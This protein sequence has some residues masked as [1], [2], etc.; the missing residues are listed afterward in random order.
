MKKSNRVG[1]WEGL[2][3]KGRD[4]GTGRNRKKSGAVIILTPENPISSMMLPGVTT[5]YGVFPAI[6]AVVD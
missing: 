2:V 6:G 3:R 5:K 1:A 4:R